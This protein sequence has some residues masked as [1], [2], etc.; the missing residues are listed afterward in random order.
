MKL[1]RWL[2]ALIMLACAGSVPAQGYPSRPI[3]LYV[4]FVPGPTDTAAR[5]VAEVAQ[6]HLGQPI[7][8]ENKPGAG[9]TLAPVLMARNAKPDG[10]LLSLVPSS[11]FRFPYM[12]KVDWD[13]IRD[14]TY[15]S[16]LT[17]DDMSI[18]VAAD[19]QFRSFGDVVRWA[20]ANPG[21]LTY[22]TPGVGT[23]MHL[24]VETAASELGIQVVQVP[25]KGASELVRALITGET[26]ITAD[27]AGAILPQ[28]AAGKAR[29]LV[30]FGEKRASWMRDVPTARELGLNMVYTVG[31]G[32]AGPRELPEAIVQIL[33]EAFRKGLEDPETVKL[34]DTLKKD[35]WTIGPAAY[36]AWAKAAVE[37]ERKMVERAGLMVK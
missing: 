7:V 10:Y 11:L 14:F 5:K 34:Y 3:T 29:Y 2:A 15:I 28:V 26:M 22:G 25:Y 31:V 9:G 13:P 36:T 37:Q 18:Q 30:Q 4:P 35:P 16:G 19:S 24:L 17:N 20:K 21:R 32:I 33:Y 8:I 27:T 23:S 12:Q 6:R 1:S